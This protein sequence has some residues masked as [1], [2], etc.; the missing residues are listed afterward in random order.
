MIDTLVSNLDKIKTNKKAIELGLKSKEFCVVTLHRPSNTDS[1][2]NL[3]L[4]L[5][6][7]I[8][9]SSKVKIIFPLHPRTE[10]MLKQF[11]LYQKLLEIENLQIIEPLGYIDFLNIIFNSTC[12]VTVSNRNS[13]S[14]IWYKQN[15]RTER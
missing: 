15:R 9:I 3:V 11:N 8:E 12:R 1:E 2:Y 14:F 7:L 5:K 6:I 13:H 4:I 10:K